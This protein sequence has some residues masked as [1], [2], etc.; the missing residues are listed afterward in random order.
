MSIGPFEVSKNDLLKERID[1]LLGVSTV[2]GVYQRFR[3]SLQEI[4]GHL[5][6]DPISW[7]DPTFELKSLRL[8][9]YRRIHDDIAVEYGVHQTDPIVFLSKIVPVLGHPLADV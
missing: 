4:E 7:G 5:E 3:Q 1:F 6:F 2:R 8:Q 9:M